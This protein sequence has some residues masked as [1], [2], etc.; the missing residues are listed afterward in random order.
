MS[1]ER[2]WQ[3]G[4]NA[5][6]FLLYCELH[7][8]ITWGFSQ[9]AGLLKSKGASFSCGRTHYPFHIVILLK[10]YSSLGSMIVSWFRSHLNEY[11]ELDDDNVTVMIGLKSCNLLE[12]RFVLLLRRT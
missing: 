7:S 12:Y 10:T 4:L 2:A 1:V 5:V 9:L 8:L 3:F 11:L 6:C